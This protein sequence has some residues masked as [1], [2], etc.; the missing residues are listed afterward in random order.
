MTV[1]H[2]DPAP[3]PGGSARRRLAAVLRG[4]LAVVALL[5]GA[6]D[7]LVTAAL[8]VAPVLPRVAR[9]VRLMA[10]RLGREISDAFRGG[11]E[12]VVDAEVIEDA[13]RWA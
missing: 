9:G 12:G 10:R 11:R 4:L 1:M 5:A 3:P 6:V 8:G 7:E 2:N 13:R